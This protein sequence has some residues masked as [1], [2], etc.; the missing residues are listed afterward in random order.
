MRIEH[1]YEFVGLDEMA[2]QRLRNLGYQHTTDTGRRRLRDDKLKAFVMLMFKLVRHRQLH[3]M[4][5]VQQ[6]RTSHIDTPARLAGLF[7]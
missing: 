5:A 1:H 2:V 7:V 6:L 3:L 4:L